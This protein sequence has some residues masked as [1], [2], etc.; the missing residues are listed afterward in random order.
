MDPLLAEWRST[1]SEKE[2]RLHKLAEVELKKVLKCPNDNDQG[3][4]FPEFCRAF[5]EFKK[6]KGAKKTN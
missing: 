6:T 2:K 1:L 4:Y 3:S 5:Q